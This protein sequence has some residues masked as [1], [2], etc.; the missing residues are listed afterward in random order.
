MRK[1]EPAWTVRPIRHSVA[2]AKSGKRIWTTFTVAWTMLW[3][4]RSPT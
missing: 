3:T 2:R 1:I 4:M